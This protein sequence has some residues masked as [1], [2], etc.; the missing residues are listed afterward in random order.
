MATKKTTHAD[1]E[2]LPS[3]PGSLD[4]QRY[5]RQIPHVSG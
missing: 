1:E 2:L 4:E 5:P 3:P